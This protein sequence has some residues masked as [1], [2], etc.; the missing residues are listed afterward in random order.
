[1][2]R[3][4]WVIGLGFVVILD[5]LLQCVK[6][7]SKWMRWYKENL[8]LFCFKVSGVV[9]SRTLREKCTTSLAS[10]NASA[11]VRPPVVISR[12]ENRLNQSKGDP[13]FY[14]C[15]VN[16]TIGSKFELKFFVAFF[17]LFAIFLSEKH[18]W[19]LGSRFVVYGEERE[20]SI[21][22]GWVIPFVH[23]TGAGGCV[24]QQQHGESNMCVWTKQHEKDTANSGE[25]DVGQTLPGMLWPI[26]SRGQGWYDG[27]KRQL[28]CL[29]AG[30]S[31]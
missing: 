6:E 25:E 29:L 7:M 9:F 26:G 31:I 16:W 28:S 2:N 5:F 14:V 22:R 24:A 30:V 1:M 4:T 18:R 21:H 3:W 8:K 10:K 17:F 20:Q 23:S 11:Q 12:E 27:T 19:C 13:N 15:N